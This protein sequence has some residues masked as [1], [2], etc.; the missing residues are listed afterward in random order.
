MLCFQF[1]TLGIVQIAVF[2][3]FGTVC[4]HYSNSCSSL[5]DLFMWP[6]RVQDT[7]FE[8]LSYQLADPNYNCQRKKLKTCQIML[9]VLLK[10]G[11]PSLR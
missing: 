5:K 11:T 10:V 9:T 6:A 2:L 1:I 4:V 3:G 8:N 7:V